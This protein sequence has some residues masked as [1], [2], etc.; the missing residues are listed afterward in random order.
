MENLKNRDH[1]MLDMEMLSLDDQAV[2]LSISAVKFKIDTINNLN[3]F[4][5]PLNGNTFN[6]TESMHVALSINEQLEKGLVL[7]EETI[8]FHLQ[9]NETFFKNCLGMNTGGDSIIT[10]VS[11]S[12]ALDC[13]EQFITKITVENQHY[14]QPIVWANGAISDH[15]W[16][17]NFYRT[18]GRSYPVDFRNQLCLRTICNF[19][20]N[21]RTFMNNHD[22]FDD[23]VNQIITLQ[24]IYQEYSRKL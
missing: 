2:V 17:S 15:K 1:V 18:Y 20:P 14:V 7:T 22:S 9:H 5:K 13:F 21:H 6:E 23:C 3:D 11:P 24:N 4:Q 16:L 19:Y 12:Q 8:V 10:K